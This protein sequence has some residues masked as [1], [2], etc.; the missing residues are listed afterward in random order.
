MAAETVQPRALACLPA[1]EYNSESRS[2][3]LAASPALQGPESV[4]GS[5]G[6]PV[7]LTETHALRLA[8]RGGGRVKEY[9]AME[10]FT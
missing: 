8:R 3:D 10:G 5:S 1:M 6:R 7:R 4:S 9:T 2:L